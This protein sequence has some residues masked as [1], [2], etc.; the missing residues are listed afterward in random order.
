MAARGTDSSQDVVSQGVL[1]DPVWFGKLLVPRGHHSPLLCHREDGHLAPLWTW[2]GDCPGP[3]RIPV[4][5][6]DLTLIRNCVE[7]ETGLCGLA[8]IFQTGVRASAECACGEV[9]VTWG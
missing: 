5:S 4:I 2:R 6:S 8:Q 1:F 3:A 7:L 9:G